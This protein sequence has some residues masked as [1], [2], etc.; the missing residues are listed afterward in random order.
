M[1]E[2]RLRPARPEDAPRLEAIAR[3]AYEIY[4]PRIDRPPAPVLADYPAMIAAGQVTLLELGC[5]G[6]LDSIGF[7]VAFPRLEDYFVENL[8]IDPL[9]QGGGHGRFLMAAA[10]EAARAASRSVVRLY[11]NEVMTENLAFYERL[12]YRVEARRLEDGYRRI[13]FA[14]TL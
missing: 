13:Y 10:E 1:D 8:A 6:S 5:E 4:L 2:R 14:K 3:A 12:G 11:T 9:R 7:L